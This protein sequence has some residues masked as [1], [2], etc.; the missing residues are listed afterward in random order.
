MYGCILNRVRPRVIYDL[1]T[2]LL[3]TRLLSFEVVGG[4][5][6]GLVPG[7]VVDDGTSEVVNVPGTRGRPLLRLPERTPLV[8]SINSDT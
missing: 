6:K 7:R 2:V 4:R 5:P 8:V 3:G 1:F